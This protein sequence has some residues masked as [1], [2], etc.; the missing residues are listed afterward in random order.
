MDPGKIIDR[1]NV[2]RFK[3]NNFLQQGQ[4]FYNHSSL[5]IN[6]RQFSAYLPFF[7]NI[8]NGARLLNVIER[9]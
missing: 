8:N 1:I 7:R 2:I 4:A 3:N 6:I 9:A 5:F